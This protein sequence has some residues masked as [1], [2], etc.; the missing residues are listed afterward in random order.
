[1]DEGVGGGHCRC[2]GCCRGR[3]EGIGE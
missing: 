2:G 1:L 3:G